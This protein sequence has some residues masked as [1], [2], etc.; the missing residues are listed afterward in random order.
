D[1]PV[2]EV[3]DSILPGMPVTIRGYLEQRCVARR[4]HLLTGLSV[5]AFDGRTVELSDGSRMENVFLCWSTG[6]KF[7]LPIA[8]DHD[9]IR[10]GRIVVDEF[11][12]VPPH[13]EVFVAGDAAAMSDRN[14]N[15]LRKAVNFSVYSGRCAGKN[16]R[17]VAQGDTPRSFTPKDLGWVIPFCNTAT[18]KLFSKV[19]V[20]GRFPLALHYFMCGYRNYNTTNRLH[21]LNLMLRALTCK[22]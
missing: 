21:F 16:V 13:P 14:G 12:R 7:G 2:I 18:G 6:T 10:D 17:R 11:L 22:H 4:L 9:T 5:Q 3:K 20:R 19:T 15:H 8:G 1:I